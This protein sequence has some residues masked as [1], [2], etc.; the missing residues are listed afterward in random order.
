MRKLRRHV[1]VALA[2]ILASLSSSCRLVST[3]R[4]I[5]RRG[6]PATQAHAQTPLTATRDELNARIAA[7]YN[8][9]GSFQATVDMT[10]SKGDIYKGQITD[11]RDFRAFV[12]FRKPASI[13][14]QALLPVVR[15]QA[16]DMVSDGANFRFYMNS[17]NLFVE[18]ANDAPANSKNTLENL[19]PDAFLASMLIRPVDPAREEPILV[20]QTDED[21]TLYILLFMAKEPG[22]QLQPRILRSIWFDR[23]DLSIIRQMVYDEKGAII[24]DTRYAKWTPYNGVLFPAHI[25]INRWK[26]GYGVVMDI[27]QLQMNKPLTNEQFV[28]NPPD[29]AQ[30]REVGMTARR[31][32]H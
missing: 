26:D 24:S 32:I 9:I 6:K 7:L 29:G 13:R 25:D 23:L 27:V 2:L 10:P 1:P 18:G 19:R 11:Y 28:L 17:K 3:P 12:L 31:E 15:T 20:D 22:G 14:I 30:I 4:T 8:S 5:F 21:A 16:F